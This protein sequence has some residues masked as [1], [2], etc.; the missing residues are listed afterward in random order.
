[1]N[2]FH[3]SESEIAAVI[4]KRAPIAGDRKSLARG[5]RY[6]Q[7]DMAA[8]FCAIDEVR[9]RHI[10]EVGNVRPMMSQYTRREFLD[11][12]A[13]EPIDIRHGNLGSADAAEAR[14]SGHAAL[15][16][17]SSRDQVLPQSSHIRRC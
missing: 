9:R 2:D 12:R 7:I 1:M 11:L 10:A 16:D 13:P 6:Q 14:R 15:P 4:R 3:Q 8:R 17:S 5:A